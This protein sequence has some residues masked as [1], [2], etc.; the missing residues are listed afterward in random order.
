MTIAAHPCPQQDFAQLL[1]AKARTFAFAARFLP[2]A[3]RRA[4]TVLYAFC[5]V[6]DDLVDEPP[7]GLEP[8]AIRAQLAAWRRWLVAD[9]TGEEPQPAE[10]A[11]ALRE[12]VLTPYRMPVP[13]LT[14]LLDGVESDLD[15]VR[16]PDFPALRR[17]AVQVAGVV[18]LAMCHILNARQPEALNAASE[19]GIAMQLTNVLRDVGGDLRG[20]RIYLPADEL[21][22]FGYSEARLRALVDSGKP[23][24]EDFRALLRFQIARARGYYARG[25]VGVWALP[26]RARPAILIAGRLYGAILDA[27]EANGYDVL[28]RRAATSRLVKAREAAAALLLTR[29]GGRR[30][31][32]CPS[33]SAV[34]KGRSASG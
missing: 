4:V 22:R 3:E 29:F 12:Q 34:P 24:D 28:H 20:D 25:L 18:G 16:M 15:V 23:P 33:P 19:L 2:A 5:R 10:L 17:Y 8:S 21:R 32:D 9:A 14:T 1:P 6:M 11:R 26:P 31:V 27:I 7:L 30:A 13:L